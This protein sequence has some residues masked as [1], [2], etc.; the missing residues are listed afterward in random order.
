MSRGVRAPLAIACASNRRR[1]ASR[2]ATVVCEGGCFACIAR[3]AVA[4]L[5]DRS[6]STGPLSSRLLVLPIGALKVAWP[7]RPYGAAPRTTHLHAYLCVS[8]R[9]LPA[10][11]I[12]QRVLGVVVEVDEGFRDV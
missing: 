10:T 4:R 5:R 2:A 1:N 8:R 6:G 7:G 11:Q 9:Q 12:E 3:A